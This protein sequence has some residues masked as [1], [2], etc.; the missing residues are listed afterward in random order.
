MRRTVLST[1]AL[2]T[3]LAGFALT[4]CGGDDAGSLEAHR[5]LPADPGGSMAGEMPPPAGVDVFRPGDEAPPSGGDAPAVPGEGPDEPAAPPQAEPEPGFGV[6]VLDDFDRTP[7]RPGA[8]DTVRKPPPMVPDPDAVEPEQPVPYDGRFRCAVGAP[9]PEGVAA[10]DHDDF[11][12]V[13]DTLC[14]ALDDVYARWGGA[15]R[16]LTWAARLEL[17]APPA[18]AAQDGLAEVERTLDGLAQLGVPAVRFEIAYPWLTAAYHVVRAE[19]VGDGLDADV[20]LSAYGRVVRAARQRGLQVVVEHGSRAADA[21]PDVAAYFA[22]V[23]EPGVAGARARYRD[24]RG[25]EAVMI[26]GLLEPD[27]V[28]LLSEPTREAA[29]FGPLGG[30]AV[31]GLEGWTG[32]L[33]STGGRIN[34]L[35]RGDAPDLLAGT[36]L[37]DDRSVVEALA[38]VAALDGIDLKMRSLG[39]GE[40]DHVLRLVEW[41]QAV[42]SVSARK[43]VALGGAW[44]GKSDPT[45][46]PADAAVLAARDADPT[47][48]VQDERFVELIDAVAQEAGLAGVTLTGTARLFR[49]PTGAGPSEGD[50]SGDDALAEGAGGPRASAEQDIASALGARLRDIM[51]RGAEPAR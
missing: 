5:E 47:W 11:A 2:I 15:R 26:A 46:A 28:V 23:R 6:G 32:Y 29:A 20:V 8:L 30:G 44:L 17:P 4:A 36:D 34:R 41:S 49:A 1:P 13:T 16:P 31:L 51:A 35:M 22:T 19:T 14:Q 25:Q 48:A 18:L 24:E 38:G 10:A 9:V 45:V 3:C 27:A 33:E 7:A 37:A 12:A 39:D 40:A 43:Y 21:A 42:R 50:P